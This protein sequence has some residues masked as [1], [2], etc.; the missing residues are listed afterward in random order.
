M[1]P[2]AGRQ[3][4]GRTP[5]GEDNRQ[6]GSRR[7]RT[8]EDGRSPRKSVSKEA[9]PEASDDKHTGKVASEDDELA[10]KA[11][12]EL[13]DFIVLKEG[14][15][16]RAWCK[17]FDTDND[18]RISQSEF[19]RG[20]RKMN[21]PGD[22]TALFA[23][24]DADHSGELALEE[25]DAYASDQWRRFRQFCV[26]VFDDAADLVRKLGKPDKDVQRGA[27]KSIKGGPVNWTITSQQF[28]EGMRAMGWSYG[29]EDILY[30]A[31]NVND[32]AAISEDDMKWIETEKRRHLR[33]VQAKQK[34]LQENVKRSKGSNVK[35]SEA[36]LA[37]FKDFLKRK[38]GNYVRAWLSALSPD[39]SMVL[40][41]NHLFK[42][43]SNIGWQGDVRILYKAFDKD[44]S[45]Y[46]SMEE[47]DARAAEIL[48]HFHKF[49]EEHFGTAVDAFHAI[50]QFN[51]KK[52]KQPEFVAA[53]KTFGFKYSGKTIFQALDHR[54]MKALVEENFY[55]LDRWKPPAFLTSAANPNAMEE[56][57]QVLLRAYKNY[58]K[59]WRHCLD[60]D[61]SNRCNYDE[62]EAAC[63]KLKY[64]GDVAGAWR[65]LD[66][67]LSGYI[68][69]QEIDSVSSEALGVFRRWCDEEFGSVRS[70]FQV[71]DS[72]GDNEVT[73]REWRRSLRI[74]GFEGNASTLFYA[75]DVERNGS[76]ALEEV[77]FLDDWSFP[78]EG[79]V[80]KDREVPTLQE[81]G[82]VPEPSTQMT[83]QYVS[84]GPGPG[85]YRTSTTMGAGPLTP[86]IHY[87]GAYSFRKKPQAKA[88]PGMQRD[89]EAM[90][91]PVDYDDL[92]A[93]SAVSPSRPQ[94]SFGTEARLA[95]DPVGTNYTD[96]GPGPG[97]YSP[98]IS[99]G[100]AVSCTPRRALKVH[101]LFREQNKQSPRP[102]SFSPRKERSEFL[103]P[104][105]RI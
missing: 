22:S 4:I 74:Y 19:I 79:E 67:D 21:Y 14:S 42:A 52:V 89:S 13:R 81:L 27:N 68:T 48:A 94:W 29:Y 91:S 83:T 39:G 72:S 3:S 10:W 65:A 60:A 43:C 99:P 50:D 1:A 105:P 16:L 2:G 37:D 97:H 84:D 25:M 66:E 36:I 69:L 45:G 49:I 47:L 35:V 44:D 92:P 54:G 59:A 15:A 85:H 41:R 102:V 82:L 57:K 61:S 38:Y 101:P 6:E 93:L 17:H 95:V 78:Q 7:S 75:L 20:M 34:A 9:G 96:P 104:L 28:Y 90:P 23:I 62:F 18:Q 24:L 76:L 77:D 71:F 87:S 64:Q 30:S 40:Q 98:M 8:G 80:A 26:N 73:Y 103:A 11:A 100:H 86:M 53:L 33:K 12:C 5:R 32:K 88:L 55:F 31:M 58:L 63:S 46:I 51:Q 70:A 56:F